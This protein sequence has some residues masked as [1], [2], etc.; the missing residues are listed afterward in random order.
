LAI[1]L[2]QSLCAY[3]V[4]VEHIIYCWKIGQDRKPGRQKP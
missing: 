2:Y 4:V 3:E 1:K